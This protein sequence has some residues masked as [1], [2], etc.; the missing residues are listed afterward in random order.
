MAKAR[1]ATLAVAAD[2]PETPERRALA[3]K[4]SVRREPLRKATLD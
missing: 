4:S 1:R 2:D 3:N